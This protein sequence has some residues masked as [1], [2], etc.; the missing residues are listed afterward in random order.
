MNTARAALRGET[1]Q[2]ITGDYTIR[3]TQSAQDRLRDA[4]RAMTQSRSF[5]DLFAAEAERLVQQ[6]VTEAQFVRAITRLPEMFGNDGFKKGDD[7]S[8]RVKAS[9]EKKIAELTGYFKDTRPETVAPGSAWAAYQ[10]VVE[11]IDHG[12]P[13]NGVADLEG[14]VRATA[15]ANL[16]AERALTAEWLTKM[17]RNAWTAFASIK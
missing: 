2:M 8:K 9:Q 6:P 10:S 5:L 16:Q 14:S 17:K 11:Y 15:V 1:G 13:V 7:A 4:T 3:H 12:K